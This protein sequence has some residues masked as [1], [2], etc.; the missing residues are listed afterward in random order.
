MR[1]DVARTRSPRDRLF[2]AASGWSDTAVEK[3]PLADETARAV[4]AAGAAT[5]VGASNC[6]PGAYGTVWPEEQFC[7]RRCGGSLRFAHV[8]PVAM[9]SSDLD[10]LL[11]GLMVQ[12]EAVAVCEISERVRL[13]FEPFA[14]TV[15]HYVLRGSGVLD[16]AGHV[17]ISFAAG[18]ML[19]IPRHCRKR[20]SGTAAVTR[21][22]SAADNCSTQANGLWRLDGT[23]DTTS[24]LLI[25]CGAIRAKCG[26]LGVFDDLTVPIVQD[27]STLNAVRV[28]F[29]SM[30]VEQARATVCS[31]A[32]IAALMTQCLLLFI[33]HHLAGTK[34]SPLFV[35]L[36]D[37]RIARALTRIL[38]RT[39]HLCMKELA[40]SV[41]M[42]RSVFAKRFSAALQASPME[43][44]RQTRLQHAADLLDTTD[45]PIKAIAATIGYASRSQFCRAFTA[46]YH[47]HPSDYRRRRKQRGSDPLL[48]V[49]SPELGDRKRM[50]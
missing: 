47:V 48:Q 18:S 17:P 3:A 7:L 37:E 8:G 26:P 15:V 40:A 46:A 35:R 5:K 6:D 19:L 32:I 22:V 23:E 27:M 45:V 28:A 16:V 10:R 2:L 31:R 21:D 43:F 39:G 12:V 1:V 20:I 24:D 41:G 9:N 33:R 50:L 36:R 49:S 11:T 29:Q 30:L 14:D 13:I 44:A 42:S 34:D 38:D 25:A 4:I